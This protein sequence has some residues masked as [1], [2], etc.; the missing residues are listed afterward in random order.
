[1]REKCATLV[2]AIVVKLVRV[3]APL[4][5][6]LMP[7]VVASIGTHPVEEPSEE[8]RLLLV[9]LIHVA[10]KK[11]G[12]AMTPFLSELAAILTVSL[13]DQ[14][15]DVK[16]ACCAAIESL[17]TCGVSEDALS[18]HTVKMLKAVLPNCGHRHSQV[19]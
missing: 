1:M 16:K 8:I 12:A 4:L 2:S 7:A 19:L 10:V 6:S 9:N 5:K 11:S 15:H 13:A 17:V 3:E 14:F 18:T